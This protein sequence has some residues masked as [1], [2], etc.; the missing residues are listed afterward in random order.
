MSVATR[1]S[2]SVM[3][4]NDE[5]GFGFI[6]PDGGGSRVFVHISAFPPAR[7]RPFVGERVDYSVEPAPDGR[8]RA[9]RVT[10]ARVAQVKKARRRGRVDVVSIVVVLG[11]AALF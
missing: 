9:A 4:W 2:G 3:E 1:T 10:S 11:F 5:R 7:T 6:S 8:P